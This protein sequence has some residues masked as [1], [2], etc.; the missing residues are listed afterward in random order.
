LAGN[1]ADVYAESLFE[2]AKEAET[3]PETARELTEIAVVMEGFP[4]LKKLLT[5]PTITVSEKQ[6][7]IAKVFG[8]HIS[9]LSRNF[10][11]VLAAK[12][13]IGDFAKV[14]VAF[15]KKFNRSQN[16]LDVFVTSAAELSDSQKE[17]LTDK[18]TKKYSKK[19]KLHFVID[20]ALV[21]GMVLEIDGRK[22]DGS[23]K[24]KLDEIRTILAAATA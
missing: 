7:I 21:G 15:Q 4:E 12:R 17:A 13:R 19:V 16:M 24:T 11:Y 1:A 18:L 20:P 3:L 9:E 23:V 10:L 5:L 2:L 8:E 22:Y 6:D 14:S